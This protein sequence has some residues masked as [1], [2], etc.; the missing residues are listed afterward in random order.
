MPVEVVSTHWKRCRRTY[1]LQIAFSGQCASI[2]TSKQTRRAQTSVF[3]HFLRKVERV[4]IVCS[5]RTDSQ[6]GFWRRKV[7]WT[8]CRHPSSI[9]PVP[10]T[11]E[12]GSVPTPHYASI[13]VELAK[14]LRSV[15]TPSRDIRD[16]H[17]VCSLVFNGL[18]HAAAHFLRK[19]EKKIFAADDF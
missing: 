13:H 14:T 6:R 12:H 10:G 17:P 4:G 11:R 16:R 19:C 2:G 15:G 8:S 9:I 3:A 5:V 7:L 1:P 18:L